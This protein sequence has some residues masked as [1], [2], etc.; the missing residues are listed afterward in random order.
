MQ[1]ANPG[2]FHTDATLAQR[3][4]FDQPLHGE[5]HHGF[6]RSMSQQKAA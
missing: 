2:A 4:F 1:G 3:I 6:V 5:P